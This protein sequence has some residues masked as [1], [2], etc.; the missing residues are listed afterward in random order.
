MS[1]LKW[2]SNA[3]LHSCDSVTKQ[4]PWGTEL[5]FVES[6]RYWLMKANWRA[7][8]DG[9]ELHIESSPGLNNRGLLKSE[10]A[11]YQHKCV[12]TGLVFLNLLIACYLFIFLLFF[13]RL[14]CFF[15]SIFNFKR[16]AELFKVILS[17]RWYL[18]C[19]MGKYSWL[20]AI[21]L[22]GNTEGSRY[23]VLSEQEGAD[24]KGQE[25]PGR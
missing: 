22:S 14:S 19:L 7:A 25:Y 24:V 20:W 2:L 1:I 17:H 6:L 16:P 4:A 3:V 8:D 21:F 23:M 5:L 9:R 15:I 13:F 10:F 12:I 18:F 11:V